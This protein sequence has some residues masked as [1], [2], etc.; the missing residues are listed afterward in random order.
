[1]ALQT[2]LVTAEEFFWMPDSKGLELIDG[3]I[4]KMSPA[5]GKHGRIASRVHISLG[6]YVQKRGLGETTIAETGYLIRRNPDT[7]RAPDVAFVQRERWTEPDGY[8]LGPPDLA[9]E[10]ISPNDTYG[11]VD[12]K[13]FDWL[14]SGV[15][16]VIVINP[17]NQSATIHRSLTE[18]ARVEIDGSLDAGDVVPGWTLPLR[19]LFV[20]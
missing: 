1:M 19:D 4:R 2:K 10:V 6:T 11:E 12:E 14:R 9:V 17:R 8:F 3:E 13:V 20:P 18:T 15:Q 7:V 5:G 16:I